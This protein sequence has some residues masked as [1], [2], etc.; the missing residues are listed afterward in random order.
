MPGI[1]RRQGLAT[2]LKNL[3]N[4]SSA[5]FAMFVASYTI[6]YRSLLRSLPVVASKEQNDNHSSRVARIKIRILKNPH[7]APFLAG[8][9]AG[10]T[11]L[12]DHNDGRRVSVSLYV[13]TKT[14]Q[15]L[16]NAFDSNGYVPE[17]PR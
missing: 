1:F 13:L 12:F 9:V 4:K 7:F 6:I 15:F 10:S 16:Y 5:R 14:A 11:M 17:M 3:A 8:A 2:I